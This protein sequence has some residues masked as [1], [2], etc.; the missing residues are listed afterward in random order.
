MNSIS[1]L[2]T[3]AALSAF[4][5]KLSNY[6]PGLRQFIEELCGVYKNESVHEWINIFQ[7]LLLERRY[8]IS[9]LNYEIFATQG[10][11]VLH[12]KNNIT[13]V[14]EPISKKT[15]NSHNEYLRTKYRT[16]L[17]HY[18][19]TQLCQSS[20]VKG[21]VD[22][23]I[24]YF[25]WVKM[26][27]RWGLYKDIHTPPLSTDNDP[28]YSFIN[29]EEINKIKMCDII[30]WSIN[31]VAD[32]KSV[33]YIDTDSNNAIEIVYHVPTSTGQNSNTSPSIKNK[34]NREDIYTSSRI[35]QG[36]AASAIIRRAKHKKMPLQTLFNPE[37]QEHEYNKS[38][39]SWY[40]R[41]I[42]KTSHIV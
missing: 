18:D 36:C 27:E 42:S 26:C 38:N 1:P 30:F 19:M 14:G 25:G 8:P 5:K 3:P 34:T 17:N 16:Q 15:I 4:I 41:Y 22:T 33:N 2:I 12:G 35:I 24:D 31:A 10:I 28:V 7:D 6:E 20:R 11:N 21:P 23:I 39:I 32:T 13:Y 29:D 37:L 9:V 40:V